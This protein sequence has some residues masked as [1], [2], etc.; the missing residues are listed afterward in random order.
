VTLH[1][2]ASGMLGDANVDP[3]LRTVE[4]C[5]RF[6][7]VERRADGRCARGLPSRLVTAAPLPASKSFAADGPGFPVVIDRDVAKGGPGSAAPTR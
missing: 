2:N 7:Q 1:S 3:M 6:E 4:L 5:P